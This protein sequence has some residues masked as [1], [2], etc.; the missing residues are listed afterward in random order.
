MTS[1]LTNNLFFL[2]GPSGSGKSTVGRL[3]A[4]MINL[5]FTDLDLFIEQQT[6]K[7]IPQIF[8]ED[9][10]SHFRQLERS[11]LLQQIDEGNAVV[12]LGGGCL[13]NDQNRA[14]AQENGFVIF[15]EASLEELEKRLSYDDNQRPLLQNN[16]SQLHERLSALLER[17]GSHYDSFPVRLNTNG[18]APEA[19]CRQVLTRLGAFRVSGMGDPYDV[20]IHN[21]GLDSLGDMLQKR[22]LKGPVALVSDTNVIQHHGERAK[23]ALLEAG[24]EVKQVVFPAG[25]AHKT[26]DTVSYCWT[27][28][29]EAGLERSSTVVALGGGVVSDLAG[30]AAS[31]YLRGCRWVVA[32]TTMLSMAD[33]SL[34]GKT[35]FDLPQGKNLVGA[36]YSPALVL[37]DPTTLLTLPENQVRNGLAEV[38]KSAVIGDPALYDI[39]RRGWKS[40]METENTL[41]NLEELACRSAAVKVNIINQDPY[42]KGIRAALNLGHTIGHGLELASN[43]EL[44]HGEA[45]AL[46]MVLEADL[47]ERI[48]LAKQGLAEELSG[49]LHGLG[50]P[51]TAPRGLDRQ[52]ILKAISRDK[53]KVQGKVRFALPVDIGEVKTGVVLDL[54]E[55]LLRRI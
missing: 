25:E 55:D 13:V 24:Y 1:L 19:V 22:G 52:T 8:A 4:D 12:A 42:E 27:A 3:M 30:F 47:A 45:V 54:N 16:S 48:G 46:G 9:G 2:Y 38:V 35:G 17:R 53:K 20:R 51:V 26:L 44:N 40:L 32:P 28:F 37:A 34:G 7:K 50:L 49:A 43:F 6:G 15:L 10:E 31:S 11:A 36:F 39:C 41:T 5:P 29:L 18:L 33:A 21:R 23:K 14:D